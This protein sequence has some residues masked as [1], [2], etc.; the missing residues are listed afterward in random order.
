MTSDKEKSNIENVTAYSDT[1]ENVAIEESTEPKSGLASLVKKLEVKKGDATQSSAV[2]NADLLP[3]P[4]EERT[5]GLWTCE[6]PAPPVT[7]AHFPQ[8]VSSGLESVRVS[9]PGLLPQRV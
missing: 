4:P 6:L 3:V 5:W 8:T 2:S 9:R 1:Q 7:V